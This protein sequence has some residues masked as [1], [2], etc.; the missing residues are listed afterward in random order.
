MSEVFFF[1]S[2]TISYLAKAGLKLMILL[3]KYGCCPT[4]HSCFLG[5]LFLYS[6]PASHAHTTCSSSPSPP[7][8]LT[9]TCYVIQTLPFPSNYWDYR[10]AH[11]LFW[12][13]F[14]P[15]PLSFFFLSFQYWG[16][17]LGPLCL[18]LNP[19]LDFYETKV[20]EPFG[21]FVGIFSPNPLLIY[22]YTYSY[23]YTYM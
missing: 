13:M 15:F 8:S 20:L 19:L 5:G 1:P 3:S 4:T 14:F 16:L 18:I 22:T 10:H 21:L 12:I 6:L 11:H 23:T 9:G 7:E 17:N 2:K